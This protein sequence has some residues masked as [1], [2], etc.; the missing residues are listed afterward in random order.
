MSLADTIASVRGG[1]VQIVFL[2]EDKARVGGGTGFLTRNR[3]VTNHHIFMGH[4]SA[5]YALIRRENTESAMLLT[6]K[7]FSTC[8]RSGSMSQ[9]FDYVIM[10][11]P[12][13]IDSSCYQFVLE[14]PGTKRI[15][16]VVAILG[17]P[18]EHYNITVHSGIVSSFYQ[19]GIAD[20][21]QLDI[22]VNPGN[23]GGPVID[24]ND[25]KVVGIVTRKATGLTA[26]FDELK[27][28][29]K[30]NIDVADKIEGGMT[31]GGFDLVQLLTAGQHQMLMTLSEIERQANVGIGYAHSIIHLLSDGELPNE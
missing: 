24:G 14:A 27:G 16:D 12:G 28:V 3:L 29:I 4:Q 5:S 13:L 26:A 17:F 31:F 9:S 20:V 18:F 25:G 21:I 22:S 23:S 11:I 8:L 19:S 6:A 7:E 30:N 10:D 15:G 1:V 2:N